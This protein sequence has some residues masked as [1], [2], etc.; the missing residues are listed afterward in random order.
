M[1]FCKDC[2]WLHI[3]QGVKLLYETTYFCTAEME[4]ISLI[5][6][7]KSKKR[8]SPGLH[9]EAARGMESYCGQE[10][11]WFEAK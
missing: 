2:K 5:T 9:A 4:I 7:E 1:K 8:R 11:K 10:G 6:G 3:S